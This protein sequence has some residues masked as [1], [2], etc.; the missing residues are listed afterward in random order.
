MKKYASPIIRINLVSHVHE[1]ISSSLKTWEEDAD[2]DIEV[3]APKRDQ[4]W[5]NW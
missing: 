1:I 3:L 2:P 4:D 5:E